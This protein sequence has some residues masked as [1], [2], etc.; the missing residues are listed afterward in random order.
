MDSNA[1]PI[2]V[3]LNLL[4]LRPGRT[5][6]TETYARGLVAGLQQ[7][8]SEFEFILFL[9]REA[10][11]T[12]ELPEGGRFRKVL[13]ASP[14][15]ASARHLWEQAMLP[16][17]SRKNGVNLLHS[18]GYVTPKFGPPSVVS[19]HDLLFAIHPEHIYFAKRQFWKVA[20]PM[21]ARRSK[22]V[23]TLSEDS[24]QD[25]VQHLGLPTEKVVVT[26]PGPGQDLETASDWRD[27]QRRLN[28]P[29]KYL[30]SV[31]SG[32]HKRIDITERALQLLEA[33][34][35][36]KL[37]LIYTSTNRQP[38]QTSPQSRDL[39]TVT[40]LDLAALYRNALAVVCV[41]A[42]EGF[43]LPVIEAMTAGAPVIVA[44]K[45]A[46]SEVGGEAAMMVPFGDA[47]QLANAI[48]RVAGEEDFRRDLAAKGKRHA[49][50]FSWSQCARQ[51][52]E[53]Y[54]R[55]LTL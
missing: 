51:T 38:A 42:M 3:G 12:F 20:V 16:A 4:Y 5:G 13:C 25:L 43:G 22:L 27:V 11:P 50:A 45:A 53:V 17:L 46:L 29:E 28:V 14:L 40:S 10:F 36:I 7:V 26:T 52:L 32:A 33:Q 30:L 44:D 49:Q 47:Q 34:Q 37:Q 55:A 31:G 2:R 54:R 48:A 19:I 18:L 8:E 15:G 39:G 1:A 24:K 23:I 35:G 21:S 6:G 9:N 41:S